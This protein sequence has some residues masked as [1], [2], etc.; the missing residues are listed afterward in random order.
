MTRCAS[1]LSSSH[2]DL[3][4]RRRKSSRSGI[5]SPLSR[6]ARRRGISVEEEEDGGVAAAALPLLR[7]NAVCGCSC[8]VS[9]VGG[10]LGDGGR[11]GTREGGARGRSGGGARSSGSN[12]AYAALRAVARGVE[13]H[14]HADGRGDRSEGT[15]PRPGRARLPLSSLLAAVASTCTHARTSAP[16]FLVTCGP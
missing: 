4:H 14:A 5:P 15:P 8:A 16:L 7:S 2:L 3:V 9:T 12:D 11:R 6:V 10:G 13:E 1:V